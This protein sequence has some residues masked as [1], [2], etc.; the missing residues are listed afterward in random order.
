MQAVAVSIRG[1][2]L[3]SARLASAGWHY[4]AARFESSR[5][6]HELMHELQLLEAMMLHVA[7]QAAGDAEAT[8]AAR[9][10]MAL[11]RCI[12][13]ATSLV[14]I[15]AVRGFTHALM[16]RQRTRLRTIRH[17][18]RNP[19]GTIRNAIA[20]LEDDS[21]PSHRR[22]PTRYRAI[23]ARNAAQADGLVTR[24]LADGALLDGAFAQRDVAVA[25][26]A[27]AVRRAL[28][29][30]ADA[31]HTEVVVADGLPVVH[32]DPASLELVLLAALA[33]VLEAA[34]ID[35]G[36][37]DRAGAANRIAV[38]PDVLCE[39]SVRIRIT[40]V[41]NRVLDAAGV[42]L[43]RD[44]AHCA[45]GELSMTEGL[46]IELPASPGQSGDDL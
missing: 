2:G 7:E 16:E 40:G 15:T 44:L 10:G 41:S 22:D 37:P 29:E 25:D 6:L 27:L 46:V 4:G 5:A 43:A 21:M 20:L 34:S 9:E 35:P 28:R 14:S 36:V 12:Q 24:E 13:R 42:I 17:D 1:S 38:E 32:T 18:L 26:V 23:I 31:A 30:E 8:G 19:L 39:R 3:V 33:G 45:G 11:A